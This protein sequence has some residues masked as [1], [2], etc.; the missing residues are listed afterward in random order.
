MTVRRRTPRV[1]AVAATV[2]LVIAATGCTSSGETS[3][4]TWELLDPAAVDPAT[5]RLEVGVTRVECSSGVTGEVREIAV[6]LEPDRIV[7]GIGLEPLGLDAA[8]CQGN[9]VVPTTVDLGA[10]IGDRD[11]VDRACLFEPV[12][13][14]SFCEDDG[15]RW[16][17]P[18]G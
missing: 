11:L 5:T 7:I 6:D 9:P 12:S 16:S 2:L 4:G 1:P 18:D 10:P 3:I 15:V 17:S 8:D 13:T 14:T